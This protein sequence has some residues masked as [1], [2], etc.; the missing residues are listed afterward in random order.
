M[1]TKNSA[2]IKTNARDHSN[3]ACSQ[4]DDCKMISYSKRTLKSVPLRYFPFL[5]AEL[6]VPIKKMAYWIQKGN[7]NEKKDGPNV[8]S[9]SIFHVKYFCS[10]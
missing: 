9:D 3:Q 1:L 4:V 10:F 6:L 8:I 2:D 5:S 7:K